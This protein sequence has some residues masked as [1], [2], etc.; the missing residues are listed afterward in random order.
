MALEFPAIK[1]A[2]L[3]LLK[4]WLMILMMMPIAVI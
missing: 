4:G 2:P 1:A 3:S